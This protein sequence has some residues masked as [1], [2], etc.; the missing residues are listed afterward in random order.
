MTVFTI[1]MLYLL[2]TI[3]RG[4]IQC[5]VSLHG[6]QF[7][8]LFELYS[9]LSMLISLLC[10]TDSDHSTTMPAKED[11]LYACLRSQKSSIELCVPQIDVDAVQKLLIRK[12]QFL[13]C[14]ILIIFGGNWRYL[15]NFKKSSLPDQLIRAN[16]RG[17]YIFI[18]E[19]IYVSNALSE[20][21]LLTFIAN[22]LIEHK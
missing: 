18:V 9:S 16:T 20:W 10:N 3:I 22:S 21:H 11:Y 2:Y 14:A 7:V 13:R 19:A 1:V 15:C 5:K 12:K 6:P 8:C 17:I 4:A